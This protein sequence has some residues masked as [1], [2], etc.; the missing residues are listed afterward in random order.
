MLL[1][2]AWLTSHLRRELTSPLADPLIFL[3]KIANEGLL[4]PNLTLIPAN[5]PAV[6]LSPLS[7]S[8]KLCRLLHLG[9]DFLDAVAPNPHHPA[10]KQA[11]FLRRIREAGIG[12]R[13][14]VMSA[15][16]SPREGA[17]ARQPALTAPQLG[18][19]GGFSAAPPPP[20]HNGHVGMA[21]YQDFSLASSYDPSPLHSPPHGQLVDDPFSALLTGVSPSLFDA[22]G[23]TMG[24]GGFFGLEGGFEGVRWEDLESDMGL[25][26]GAGAQGGRGFFGGDF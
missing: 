2:C 20:Q 22:S 12:G 1:L 17:V 10:V 9:A 4:G 24:S 3:A 15:P 16:G 7:P 8:D 11:A 6:P 25:G 18:G 19:T 14:S 21:P 26:F 23:A 5:T 13:R